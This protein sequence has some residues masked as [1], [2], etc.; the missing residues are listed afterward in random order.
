[1]RISAERMTAPLGV[2]MNPEN[3]WELQRIGLAWTS[4]KTGRLRCLV[5]AFFGLTP[6]TIWVPYATACMSRSS[7][8]L[9][10]RFCQATKWRRPA[11]PCCSVCDR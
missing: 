4:L 1:M 2:T 6:P 3:F 10:S 7:L 9:Q 11:R 5:P 8:Q